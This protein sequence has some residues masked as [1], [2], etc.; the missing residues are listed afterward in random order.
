[1]VWRARQLTLKVKFTKKK[2][3]GQSV[4]SWE[5]FD[6]IKEEVI[7]PD[8]KKK[9]YQSHISL[10][11]VQNGHRMEVKSYLVSM[12]I[13]RLLIPRVRGLEN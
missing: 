8:T 11:K 5:G 7:N 13:L 1:M 6:G 3:S 2:E 4:V 12:V 10:I 9:E